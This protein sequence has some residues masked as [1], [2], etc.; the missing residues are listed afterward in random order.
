[1]GK[2]FI[3]RNASVQL[4]RYIIFRETTVL[5][6]ETNLRISNLHLHYLYFWYL[7]LLILKKSLIHPFRKG[8][9]I[10][11]ELMAFTFPFPIHIPIPI[12][13]PHFPVSLLNPFEKKFFFGY[14]LG[15][16]WLALLVGRVRKNWSRLRFAIAKAKSTA[17]VWK[18]WLTI[19]SLFC[20]NKR[21]T[22]QYFLYDFWAI[23]Q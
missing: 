20:S 17:K 7:L 2:L 10:F 19:F 3:W 8:E 4:E 22:N 14:S 1:M 9:K 6:I 23:E 18:K 13:M 12:S 11:F 5:Y 21:E 15:T 16:R